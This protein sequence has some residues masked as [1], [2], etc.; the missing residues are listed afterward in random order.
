MIVRSLN[1][2]KRRAM[3]AELIPINNN[4][5]LVSGARNS[6]DLAVAAWLD[7]KRGRS[8]S[9]NTGKI[10]ASTITDFR[11]ALQLG[12]LD[13][14]ADPRAVALTAQAWAGR[15]TPAPAT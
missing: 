15:N 4:Q 11:A 9:A 3:T 6:I 12:G 14:D 10:Y 7:S 13:L 8:G 1:S 2:E 5:E